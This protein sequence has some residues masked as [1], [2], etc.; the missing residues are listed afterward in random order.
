[1]T[2]YLTNLGFPIAFVTY[3]F[4]PTLIIFARILDVSM[5]TVRLLLIMNGKAN[6]APF[7]GAVEVFL[8]IS[9]VGQIVK[10][11]NSLVAYISYGIGFGLGTYIG[12]KIEEYLAI[13]KVMIKLVTVKP[14]DELIIYL[15]RHEIEFSHVSA[16]TNT[17]NN[18]HV[19]WAVIERKILPEVTTI[20]KAF[21]PG[22]QFTVSNIKS[23]ENISTIQERKR[24]KNKIKLWFKKRK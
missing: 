1:M 6:I 4:L 10:G 19:I 7:V 20:M 24:T 11:E 18:S 21:N 9:I 14:A 5:S 12:M 8:W 15:K 3:L 2:E 16:Q 22:S 13:G 17:N 23:S